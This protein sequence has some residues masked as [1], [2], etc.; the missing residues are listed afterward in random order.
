MFST[1]FKKSILYSQAFAANNYIGDTEKSGLTLNKKFSGLK[2]QLFTHKQNMKRV[3][4]Q[5]K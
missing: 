5:H 3:V 4:S 2:N 1:L